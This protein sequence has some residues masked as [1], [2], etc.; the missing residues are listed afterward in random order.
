LCPSAAAADGIGYTA[1]VTAQAAPTALR[2]SEPGRQYRREQE[3]HQHETSRF[4]KGDGH[5]PDSRSATSR[6]DRLPPD[7]I[8]ISFTMQ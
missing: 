7:L 8:T 5:T 2:Q 6:L 1:F 3:P 4:S